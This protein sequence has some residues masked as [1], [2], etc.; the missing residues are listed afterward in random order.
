MG[1]FQDNSASKHSDFSQPEHEDEK[2]YQTLLT[3]ISKYKFT[4]P[5]LTHKITP[6]YRPKM[7]DWLVEVTTVFG[8]NER[9]YFLAV[10]VFDQYLRQS[11]NLQNRDVHL[12]GLTALYLASKYEDLKPMGS[13][14]IADKIS[15]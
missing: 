1:R 2:F 8:C 6:E 4:N 12:V 3:T 13:E 14:M 7:L 15:H 10:T 5:I 9:T 11:V